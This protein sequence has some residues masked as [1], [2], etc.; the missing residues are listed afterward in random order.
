MNAP[1]SRQSTTLS[2]PV[3]G[4]SC[5]SCVKRV[6]TA[7]AKLP[8]VVEARANFANETLTVSPGPDFDATALRAAIKDAGYE[9]PVEKL[10]IGI[11]GMSCASCVKRVEDALAGAPGIVSASVNL[12]TERAT[13]D[14]VGGQTGLAAA[15]A[16]ITGAGYT[17]H[18]LSDQNTQSREQAKADEIGALQRDVVISGLLTLPLFVLEMGSHFYA[19]FHQWLMQTVPMGWLYPAYFVLASAVLFGPGRRFFVKGSLSLFECRHF[20]PAISARYGA[21]HLFRGGGGYRHAHSGRALARSPRQGADQRRHKA[22]RRSAGQ[23]GP[24][25]AGW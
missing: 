11:E 3:E 15:E 1:V 24:R 18:R 23:I 19:P 22:A 5:A 6:E 25:V 10:E 7:A 2:F 16:A 8:G 4:M 17:P 21:Q 12:A 14:I 20:R 13:L 9:L